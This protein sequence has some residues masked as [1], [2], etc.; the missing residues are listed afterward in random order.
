M[1]SCTHSRT[2]LAVLAFFLFAIPTY[3]HTGSR[4]IADETATTADQSVDVRELSKVVKASTVVINVAGRDGKPNAVG[5]GFVI[6]ADGQ[7][8]TNL[9]VI[10]EGREISVRFADDQTRKVQEILA[11][12]AGL[13]LAILQV[14][15][16][17]LTPLK[18]R[19]DKLDVGEQVMAIGTPLGLD[20]SIVTGV[21][22]ALR[23]IDKR[24]LIQIAM[25]I[26]PGNS[27][28]PLVDL[29]GRVLG[30]LTLKSA[31]TENLG[32]A[33]KA[34]DLQRLIELPNPIPMSQWIKIRS[35][36]P[37]HWT[38]KFGARWQ[39]RSGKIMVSGTADGFGG[40]SLCLSTQKPIEAPYE[41]SVQ[42]K[43]NDENGAAGLVFFADGADK[44]YGFYPSNGRLRLSCFE[45]PSPFNWNVLHE[46]ASPQYRR[47]EW[48]HLRV[49]VEEET[50]RC[51][52]NDHLV[53]E[54][55]DLRS[56]H[57]IVGLAK[58]RH[59]IAE[60]KD[61]SFGKTAKR[62]GIAADDYAFL[63][64][65]LA[66]LPK[67][68]VL[69]T[70]MLDANATGD[71]SLDFTQLQ[72]HADELKREAKRVRTLA[73]DVNTRQVA[74][75]LSEMFAGEKDTFDLLKASLLVSKIDNPTL[76]PTIYIAEVDRMARW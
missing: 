2:T 54:S 12:D 53:V 14:D 55:N 40:R 29:D 41:L 20:Y 23:T 70:G 36:N 69:Q 45:G 73:Y 62:D 76:D 63:R 13:D 25:P 8:A 22:S 33:V 9:H 50:I 18:L 60:F 65:T 5:T 28:G 58:F 49:R 37:Q 19:T 67:R 46:A 57:A 32:F 48:N 26:E 34:S 24:E 30:I 4:L 7:I 38:T 16:K 11:S 74:K 3:P 66:T 1:V 75:Q 21:I 42:V 61:F 56:K 43:M 59:T 52:I 27:G 6:S 72:K 15:A 39:Q 17:D 71:K 10:G 31:I 64:R 51:Y 44:H 35:M 68:E 47:G